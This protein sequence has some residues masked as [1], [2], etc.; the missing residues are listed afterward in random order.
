MGKGENP[1]ALTFLV[2]NVSNLS[3]YRAKLVTGV[4][5]ELRPC[6]PTID[7]AGVLEEQSRKKWLV[8]V[9]TSLSSYAKHGSKLIDALV[10]PKSKP[11][12][13][14]DSLKDSFLSYYA[15]LAGV[16]KPRVLLA[17]M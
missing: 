15:S 16:H 7:S 11:K 8:F 1:K 3:G 13:L 9:Q 14:K 2:E 12:E 17:Y 5:Y 10:T 6:H 4:L